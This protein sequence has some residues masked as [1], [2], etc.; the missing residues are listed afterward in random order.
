[1]PSKDPATLTIGES[2]LFQHARLFVTTVWTGIL[3]Q[4]EDW[5]YNVSAV[6]GASSRL[7]FVFPN[8]M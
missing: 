1:M 4:N 7:L 8:V 3:D 6:L 5:V 2:A